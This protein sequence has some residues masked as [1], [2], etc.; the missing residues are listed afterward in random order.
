MSVEM[1]E[2]GSQIDVG[3]TKSVEIGMYLDH[4]NLQLTRSNKLS[5]PENCGP[6]R[7]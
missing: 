2:E 5:K 7:G 6:V 1:S 4:F 3:F